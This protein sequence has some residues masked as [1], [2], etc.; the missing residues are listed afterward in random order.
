[1]NIGEAQ[2][3]QTLVTWVLDLDCF[4]N[5]GQVLDHQLVAAVAALS[6]RA[7]QALGA[8]QRGTQAGERLARI[9]GDL[10]AQP[11]ET[12]LLAEGGPL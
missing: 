4:D 7:F 9:L 8:G 1:M 6:E 5:R 10:P 11:V 12:V 2:Q 3:V